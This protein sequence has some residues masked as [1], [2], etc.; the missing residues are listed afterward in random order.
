MADVNREVVVEVKVVP[1]PICPQCKR[2]QGVYNPYK[3]PYPPFLRCRDCQREWGV[4]Y[5]K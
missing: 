1:L 4:Q 3:G 2:T 5:P